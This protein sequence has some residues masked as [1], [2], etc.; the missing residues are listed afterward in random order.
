MSTPPAATLVP[1][2]AGDLVAVVA[3]ADWLDDAL[4]AAGRARLEAHGF[5]VL[6][7][8]QTALR[9]GRMAGPDAARL[10]ALGEVL[11][12][13]A[14][15]AVFCARGG[16]G[17]GRLLD[18]L[19]YD[20]IAADPKPIIGYSDITAL[21]NA[22]HRHAGAVTVHGPVLKEIAAGE[23]PVGTEILFELLAGRWP[24]EAVDRMLAGAT[25]LRPGFARAPLI[26]GNLTLI[27]AMIGTRHDVDTRGRILFLEDWREPLY[28]LDRMLFHLRQVGKFDGIAGLLVGTIAEI[29]ERPAHIG[30]TIDELLADHFGDAP[31]P[32]AT[33]LE[34]GHGKDKVP[35][36]LGAMA[37]MRAGDGG[38]RLAVT[39]GAG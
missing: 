3:P 23:N 37:E 9:R 30:G 6:V 36:P 34:I 29:D 22:V 18:G 16:Y 27:H 33:N 5:R 15:R 14:V 38:L 25:V 21:L 32:V 19:D 20:A 17:A 24:Q 26:G 31:F 4:L 10:A 7:H 11:A 1:L 28:H 2:R 12:D 35:L 13:P 8:P 39:L